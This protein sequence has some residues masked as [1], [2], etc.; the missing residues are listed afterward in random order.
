[1]NEVFFKTLKHETLLLTLDLRYFTFW[2][3]LWHPNAC[4]R[5]L[6]DNRGKVRV[7][8]VW[9]KRRVTWEEG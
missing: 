4:K 6:Q 8:V 2:R 1:M 5:W 7:E 3:S 9:G